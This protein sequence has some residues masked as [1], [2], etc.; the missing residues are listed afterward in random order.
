MNERAVGASAYPNANI[1][2]IR[3][4]SARSLTPRGCTRGSVQRDAPA[5]VVAASVVMRRFTLDLDLAKRALGK[6][7][8]NSRAPSGR[9]QVRRIC[10]G[11]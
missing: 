3:R 6:G 1:I 11:A 5:A 7:E 9:F 4:E 10:C 2:I 8:K